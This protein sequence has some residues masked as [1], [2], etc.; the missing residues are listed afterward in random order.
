MNLKC[1][2]FGL[3]IVFLVTSLFCNASDIVIKNSPP[4]KVIT[5]GNSKIMITLD[6]NGRCAVTGLTVDGRSV[7]EGPGGIYSE[8]KTS[9]NT[10][11]TLN[12]LSVPTIMISENTVAISNIKYG[13]SEAIAIENWDFVL[14]GNDIRF[15]IERTFP[16]SLVVEEAA[17]PSFNFNSIST[18]N[19][20]FL[21]YGGLAWFYLFN[22]KLCTY[23][24]HSGSSVFWN[25]TTGNAL[26]VAVSANGKKVAMK[27]SRSADDHLIYNIAVSD[28]ELTCRYEAEKRSRFIRGKTNV[29]DSF[30]VPAGKYVQTITLSALNYNEIYNRGTLLGS[31]VS[32]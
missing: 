32:R 2:Q 30:T 24:V 27:V 31:T 13:D 25:S 15:E 1:C 17:F 14:T 18:W 28:S 11:S 20:A 21:G 23:G 29:W 4:D 10:Y 7:I 12:L 3:I 19:G 26:K 8:I 22:Q 16:K 5:F 6:Y 9:T